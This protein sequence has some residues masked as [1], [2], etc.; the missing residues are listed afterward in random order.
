MVTLSDEEK[1]EVFNQIE[2]RF[3]KF[4][5]NVH[6]FESA[7]GALIVGQYVGWKVLLLMHD[8][9]TIKK[10]GDHLDIDYKD[11]MEP[12]GKR[13]DKS[14]AWNLMKKVEDFWK[15]IKGE[16]KGIKS[17]DIT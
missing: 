15:V 8:R 16:I 13:A 10:Y 6:E 1:L 14:I 2:K 11:W 17:P 9:K 7:A 4:K 5:G 12:I 3:D